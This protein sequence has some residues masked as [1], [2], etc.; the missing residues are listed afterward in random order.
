MTVAAA[1]VEKFPAPPSVWAEGPKAGLG[2]PSF[3]GEI[4]E[5]VSEAAPY[6]SEK[7]P[8]TPLCAR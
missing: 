3:W 2:R 5:E 4:V 7:D 6:K 1:V 8:P